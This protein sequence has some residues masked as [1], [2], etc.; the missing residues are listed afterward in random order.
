MDTHGGIYFDVREKDILRQVL[1]YLAVKHIFAFRL[2]TGAFFGDYH[3]RSWAFKAHSLG[4]GAADILALPATGVLWI[5]VK[6]PYGRQRP[7]Q[8]LFEQYVT[9]WGHRYVLARS[10]DDLA[11]VL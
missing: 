9:G 6:A 4:P 1:D 7:A 8:K 11:G 5:E 3:G 2:G 10:V